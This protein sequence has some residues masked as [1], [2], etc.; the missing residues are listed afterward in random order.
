MNRCPVH[1]KPQAPC[2][3]CAF[4]ASPEGQE[5]MARVAGWAK[6]KPDMCGQC[7]TMIPKGGQCPNGH[8]VAFRKPRKVGAK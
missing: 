8:R 6:A 1:T 4:L 2:S 5:S 3:I 7:W